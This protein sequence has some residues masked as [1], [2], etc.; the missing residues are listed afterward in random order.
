MK[1]RIILSLTAAISLLAVSCEKSNGGLEPA[2]DW[3]GGAI[4]EE[5]AVDMNLPVLWGGYNVGASSVTETGNLY[6]WGETTVKDVC[7]LESSV[8]YN[9]ETKTYVH[10]GT[11]LAD[12]EDVA[13]KELGEGWRMPTKEEFKKLIDSCK[14]SYAKYKGVSGY[15]L[16]RLINKG[17]ENESEG[18]SI[19]FPMTGYKL[20][21]TVYN[22][23]MQ[24]LYWANEV[25]S[26][27][28]A[29]VF[30][31]YNTAGATTVTAW[32]AIG[33]RGVKE[34]EQN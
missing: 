9:E 31:R 15:V 8:F 30:F 18:N 28:A 5:Q 1:T 24:A 25:S 13:A 29:N 22:K 20:N 26:D 27:K 19:F 16:T 4:S 10:T 23:E 2:P 7:S 34:V 6:C 17:K 32:Y 11:T 21:A 14:V 3:K 12:G 33:V